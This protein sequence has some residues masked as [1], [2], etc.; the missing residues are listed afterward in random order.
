M[1]S[2]HGQKYK[3]G[4]VNCKCKPWHLC[5]LQQVNHFAGRCLEDLQGEIPTSGVE[6]GGLRLNA[7]I[8]AIIVAQLIFKLTADWLT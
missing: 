6:A 1:N 3:C 7:Q 8:H 5:D 2:L 4:D